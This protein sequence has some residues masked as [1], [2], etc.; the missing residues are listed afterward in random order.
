VPATAAN[1]A[2]RLGCESVGALA[3]RARPSRPSHALP[4]V[5]VSALVDGEAPHTLAS[6][7]PRA[8]THEKE[9]DKKILSKKGGSLRCWAPCARTRWRKAIGRAGEVVCLRKHGWREYIHLSIYSILGKLA[10]K[11]EEEDIATHY[12]ITQKQ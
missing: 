1:M 10:E 9:T 8:V 7:A 5:L 3:R 6:R 2:R 11:T 12:Y 4:M